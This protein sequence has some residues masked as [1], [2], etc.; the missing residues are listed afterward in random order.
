MSDKF[1][2]CSNLPQ[3]AALGI[4]MNKILWVIIS[5]IFALSVYN[6]FEEGHF[7]GFIFS[8]FGFIAGSS[9]AVLTS[10]A[11]SRTRVLPALP[12]SVVAVLSVILSL[13]VSIFYAFNGQ[14]ENSNT[15]TSQMHVVI[16]PLV[17][18]VI[19]VLALLLASL[20]SVLIKF[21][22]RNIA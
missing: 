19:N 12:F 8:N 14:S 18:L 22:R 9:L 20:A 10:N 21:S 16:V 11:V 15:S 1:P 7:M 13:V 17:L 3:S 2:L 6:W 4:K 5:F